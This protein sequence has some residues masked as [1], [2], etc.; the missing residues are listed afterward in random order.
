MSRYSQRLEEMR[1]RVDARSDPRH[2]FQTLIYLRRF[3]NILKATA[4]KTQRPSKRP[5][6]TPVITALQIC[7]QKVSTQTPDTMKAIADWPRGAGPG[8]ELVHQGRRAGEVA[9]FDRRVTRWYCCSEN[10]LL[11]T[12]RSGESVRRRHCWTA[13]WSP[14]G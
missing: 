11:P 5:I 2:F 10:W 7:S 12:A 14:S 1:L 3:L 8:V 9:I 6:R 13:W 4:P